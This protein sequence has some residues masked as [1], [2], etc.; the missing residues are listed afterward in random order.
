M[1]NHIIMHGDDKMR[2][3]VLQTL[4]SS[5]QFRGEGEVMGNVSFAVSSGQKSRTVYDAAQG[6]IFPVL[7]CSQKTA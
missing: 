7:W 2:T 3:Y 1:M 6:E 5:T 4:R